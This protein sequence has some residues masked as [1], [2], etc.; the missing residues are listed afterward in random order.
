AS[1]LSLYALWVA[2]SALRSPDFLPQIYR[3]IVSRTI[4]GVDPGHVQGASFYLQTVLASSGIVPLVLI[5]LGAVL[6][7][8]STNAGLRLTAIW[9]LTVIVLIHCSVSKLKWYLDPV[10]PAL[11]ILAAVA[12]QAVIVKV[13]KGRL[14]FGAVSLVVL[15]LLSGYQT[16]AAWNFV[17]R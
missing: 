14:A 7:L 2:D 17:T 6:A 11:A 8:R 12:L 10:L 3:D 4:S 13:T 5:L 1:G 9:T 15:G 16:L